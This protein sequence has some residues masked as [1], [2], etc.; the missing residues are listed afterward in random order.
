MIT[1]PRFIAFNREAELAKRLTCSG[2]TARRKATPSAPGIYYDAF[3]GLS[4]GLERLAKLAWLIDECI[5]RNGTFPTDKELCALSSTSIQEPSPK[6]Q[7]NSRVCTS[8]HS[9]APPP[10]LAALSFSRPSGIPW[11]FGETAPARWRRWQRCAAPRPW[12]A[13]SPL[14]G[15]GLRYLPLP[16]Q[17]C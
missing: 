2:L 16:S 9:L 7:G 4:I 6:R 10:R 15:A 5:R 1:E 17:A 14:L 8:H 3:F 11:A 13:A 12:S